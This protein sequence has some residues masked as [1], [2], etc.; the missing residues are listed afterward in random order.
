M[1]FP[2]QQFESGFDVF[3]HNVLSITDCS[4]RRGTA[5]PLRFKFFLTNTVD[6]V[7]EWLSSVTEFD[8]K[9]IALVSLTSAAY[10]ISDEHVL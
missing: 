9:A 10:L 2:S 7:I 6:K 5:L 8:L 3:R 1:L 4:W